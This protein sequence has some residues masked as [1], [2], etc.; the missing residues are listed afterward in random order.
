MYRHNLA[1]RMGARFAVLE[2]G[3]EI[4]ARHLAFIQCNDQVI[5][6]LTKRKNPV[7][8]VLRKSEENGLFVGVDEYEKA[9]WL[10]PRNYEHLASSPSEC[11]DRAD[12]FHGDGRLFQTNDAALRQRL[13]LAILAAQ[14][15]LDVLRG[16][17]ESADSECELADHGNW[18]LNLGAK[19][20]DQPD[21]DGT[22]KIRLRLFGLGGYIADPRL[23]IPVGHESPD[24]A[25]RTGSGRPW[26]DEMVASIFQIS[27]SGTTQFGTSPYGGTMFQVDYPWLLVGD[28]FWISPG[29]ALAYEYDRKGYGP[30]VRAS[31]YLFPSLKLTMGAFVRWLHYDKWNQARDDQ[32]TSLNLHSY[33]LRM[34]YGFTNT[35]TA[36]LRQSVEILPVSRE[37]VPVFEVLR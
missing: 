14:S 16:T 25:E 20:G 19:W 23:A 5:K 6:H 9:A 36:F 3:Q 33:G 7:I 1:N 10:L 26:Y 37:R 21:R 24:G 31:Y 22:D 17:C 12:C 18:G 30:Q 2:D 8:G 15:I 29:A 28:K 4:I 27:I 35:I 32:W 34:D 11:T 13:Y